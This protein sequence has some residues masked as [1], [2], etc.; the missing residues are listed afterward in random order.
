MNGI[1]LKDGTVKDFDIVDYYNLFSENISKLYDEKEG[2]PEQRILKG[3]I[4]KNIGGVVISAKGS[5]SRLA[6]KHRVK[7]LMATDIELFAK[8]DQNGNY[9][10]NS[11]RKITEEE[12]IQAYDFLTMNNKMVT[13]KGLMRIFYRLA[14]GYTFETDIDKKNTLKRSK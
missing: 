13:A 10:P 12:K 8:F 3:F 14:S 1:V 7:E 2:Q 11:G 6:D 4:L 5:D 9:I